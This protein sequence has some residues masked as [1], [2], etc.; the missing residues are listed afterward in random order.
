MTFSKA[1]SRWRL[2]SVLTL[3]LAGM[4]ATT[5]LSRT[6]EGN[7]ISATSGFFTTSDG[8]RLHYLQKG[9]GRP[10]VL[11]PGWTWPADIYEPQIRA[12]SKSHRVIALDPR[13]QGRSEDGVNGQ[14][15]E[16]PR[17]AADIDE[18]IRHLGLSNVVLVGWEMASMEV[19]TYVDRFG[20]DRLGAVVLAEGYTWQPTPKESC[21]GWLEAVKQL[22]GD[23]RAWIEQAIR[24][25]YFRKPHS[26]AYFQQMTEAHLRTPTGI[27][28]WLGS[29][30]YCS[31]NGTDQRPA[32]TKLASA[33]IPLLY[34]YTTPGL[35]PHAEMVQRHISRARVE[36]IE[37][38]GHALP[39]DDP[40][41]FNRVLE[42]FLQ[43]VSARRRQ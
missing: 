39:A 35:K 17:L 33:S 11:V 4:N 22:H 21:L 16:F 40:E 43:Q 9:R 26:E 6:S 28:A 13:A 14:G 30:S 5:A 37:G 1:V 29:V 38:A 27:A 31:P 18:L 8:V 24:K 42:T 3:F 19:L 15:Y 41:R 20:T 12:L 34:V 32:L 36:M 10:I 2:A 25:S 23:R 7:A